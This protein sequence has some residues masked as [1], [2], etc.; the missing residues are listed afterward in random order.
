MPFESGMILE[1][2]ITERVI[3]ALGTDAFRRDACIVA[4]R[5]GRCPR[6]EVLRSGE[7]DPEVAPQQ[8]SNW[9]LADSRIAN[10]LGGVIRV[11]GTDAFRSNAGT[12]A[13]RRG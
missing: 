8:V 4:V 3:R 7:F 5:R 2:R 10:H 12:E 9:S 11:L 1:K 13:A 6:C